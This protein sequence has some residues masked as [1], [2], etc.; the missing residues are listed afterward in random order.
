MSKQVLSIEQML[1]LQELGFD[2]SN[3]SASLY[4]PDMD[5]EYMLMFG[6]LKK[7]ELVG[8]EEDIPSYTLQ[9]VL[10][11]L[12]NRIY[13]KGAFYLGCYDIMIDEHDICYAKWCGSEIESTYVEI[14]IKDNLIDAA[15]SMLCWCVENKFVETNKND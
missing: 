1:H 10:D 5:T 3:A 8:N 15:Y 7:E 2:T 14:E 9:D 13:D 4:K 11:A 6:H 12:P